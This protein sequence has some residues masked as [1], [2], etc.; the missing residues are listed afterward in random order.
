M[1]VTVALDG[2]FWYDTHRK[3]WY[4]AAMRSEKFRSDIT[5]CIIRRCET[6]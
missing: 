4:I 2:A 3:G 5:V 6:G 1:R